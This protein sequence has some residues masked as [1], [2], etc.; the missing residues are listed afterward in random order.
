MNLLE[1]RGL[2]IAYGSGRAAWTAV[3]DFSVTV[4]QGGSVGLI[5]ESGSGKS[6]VARALIGLQPIAS[7]EIHLAGKSMIGRRQYV[8][9]AVRHTVQLVFQDPY[10]SLNPRMS[11]QQVLAEALHAQ[12]G[13]DVTTPPQLLAD[14]GLTNDVLRR[15]PH[16]LSGGQRQRV[17]IAR[18]LACRPT[19]LIL[20]EVTS[21]LD[22][23]VQAGVLNLL[24]RIRQ[25]RGISLLMISHDLAVIR[26]MCDEIVVIY[27]GRTME[28]GSSA[29]ILGQPAH[30][31]TRSLLDVIPRLNVD[32]GPRAALTR[33]ELTDP[34]ALPRGCVFS[35]RCP[36]AEAS[37][38]EVA[39]VLRPMSGGTAAACHFPIEAPQFRTAAS[40]HRDSAG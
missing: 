30:H 5:G 19:M 2:S 9:P 16:E 29:D 1:V 13:R 40:P 21:A 17:A 26:Y 37:C 35:P 36:R 8:S 32:K 15:Y 33:G 14:V 34:R 7:G 27:A 39:P 38:R 3:S 23:S 12:R 11:V 28:V 20:D 24:R 25:E 6:T 22:V 31:Y 18:A 10:A 4:P